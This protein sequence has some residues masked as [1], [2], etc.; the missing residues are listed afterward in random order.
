MVTYPVDGIGQGKLAE[1]CDLLV[2]DLERAD[3]GC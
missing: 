3:V 2:L 1:V